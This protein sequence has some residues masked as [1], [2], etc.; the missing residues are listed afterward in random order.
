MSSGSTEKRHT[1]PV[2]KGRQSGRILITSDEPGAVIS[3]TFHPGSYIEWWFFHGLF[4]GAKCGRRYLMASLFR[5]DPSKTND[6][7][8]VGY[9]LLLSLFDPATGRTEILSRGERAIIDR[10]QLP[11]KSRRSPNID[12]RVL[13]VYIDELR[14][15]GPPAPIT[16]EDDRAAVTEEPFSLVWKDFSF[17][18][19]G[20][21]FQLAFDI[22]G[23]TTRC[24]LSLHPVSPRH[25]MR[26][27]GASL[28]QP[29]AY[30]TIPRLELEGIFEDEEVSG[31]AWFDHQ[32]GSAC[33]F[34]T[35]PSGGRLNGWDWIAING[36]D[37][38]DWIFLI[39]HDMKS[40]QIIGKCATLYE[41]GKKPRIFKDFEAEPVRFWESK[42]THITY[43]VSWILK[44]PA[45]SAE[46]TINPVS[47]DQE[48]PVLGF[49][50]AVWEGAATASG[51]VEK[52]RFSGRARLE[53]Q[54][55]G[56]IFD[57]RE[58]LA[59]YITRIHESIGE[60]FPETI[61][62]VR[63][64]ELAGTPHWH[65]ELAACNEMIARPFWDL[66]SRKKKYWRPVFGMLL[67]ESLGVSMEK[68]RMLIAVV[69]ELTHTGTLIID[70]IEDNAT[71]RR[72][73]ACIHKRYGLDVAINAANTLYFLPAALYSTHP[74]LTDRQRL[75]FYRI[76]LDGYIRGHL[77]QAL[78]IYWTKNLSIRNLA[79]WQTDHLPEKMLQMYEFKTASTA[80]VIADACCILAG[81]DEPTRTACQDL[82]RSFG[83]SF[84]ILN[85]IK[86]FDEKK[87]GRRCGED[88]ASGKITYVIVRAMERLDES[89][90]KRLERIVC[91]KRLRSN[92]V[93][94][95]EG[96][97]LVRKSG[98][99]V[100][101]RKEARSMVKEGWRSFSPHIPPSEHKLMLGLFSKTLIGNSKNN[102]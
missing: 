40:K 84:Q 98:A 85:D 101:C 31:E 60:F 79:S 71:T 75:E 90:R 1:I 16:L 93:Y 45:I 82:A 99:L 63:Y 12:P 102:R 15:D 66:M 94:L 59:P 77:G 53:L 64:Q 41:P 86:D 32:W 17:S 5:Y 58:Y 96:I 20:G 8:S 9:Y 7:G 3:E 18:Q 33:W 80:V 89:D 27:I 30:A 50:R 83:V 23:G 47:D 61:D 24:R 25:D 78:D 87:N 91:S 48:I 88:L 39:F 70:D 44:I 10:M 42:R 55:Y 97:G 92:P 52:Q 29:M 57:F 49:M 21:L 43:P 100:S 19:E 2:K 62:A 11:I 51:T 73:D 14:S 22:P 69:P 28:A 26:G 74:H 4:E 67:L 36:K 81:S 54:G 35:Q 65:H 68:Y 37:G 38:S 34:L 6:P 95:Q 46:I 76:T 72:G 56:Y 13:E